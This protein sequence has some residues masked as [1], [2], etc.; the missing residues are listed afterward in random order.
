MP[1]EFKH[2][3]M[4]GRLAKDE[5]IKGF[6]DYGRTAV[7][8]N[9]PGD[10]QYKIKS[11]STKND[12]AEEQFTGYI[13]SIRNLEFVDDQYSAPEYRAANTPEWSNEDFGKLIK[14]DDA[15]LQNQTRIREFL[16]EM[17]TLLH[18]TNANLGVGPRIVKSIEMYL[19][20]LPEGD[21]E[22][23]L[24]EAEGLDYQVAQR[25]LTKI[26]GPEEQLKELFQTQEQKNALITLLD[27]IRIICVK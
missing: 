22:Y 18:G 16:W 19:R 11:L 9:K 12:V 2:I 6:E 20:N 4:V 17:H 15:Q 21:T 27:R 26:R 23:V 3:E 13:S 7:F 24:S 5:E 8:I 10:I 25:I 1:I 14:K